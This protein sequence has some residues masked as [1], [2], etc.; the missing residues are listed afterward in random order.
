MVVGFLDADGPARL[1][2]DST[3]RTGPRDAL[4]VLHRGEVAMTYDKHHLPNYGVFDENRYF[5]PG[6]TLTV[7]RAE[8]AEG[9]VDIALTV[10]EDI[11]QP[12]G[13]FAAAAAAHV[14]LIVN[15]NA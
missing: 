3:V 14:G 10:C 2:A 8:T 9:P 13:P 7:I 6:D 12:G 1:G 11:W 5:V 15:I 4:A